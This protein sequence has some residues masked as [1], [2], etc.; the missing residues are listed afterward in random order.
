MMG[1]IRVLT[2]SLQPASIPR[3]QDFTPGAV[4]RLEAGDVQSNRVRTTLMRW[5]LACAIAG[6]PG[7]FIWALFGRTAFIV[8]MGIA[9][10]LVVA[11][12]YANSP[13]DHD[14]L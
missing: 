5:L 13:G 6:A 8:Y 3:A 2:R 4:A 11:S 10:V 1:Q 12:A 9:A 14:L 7:F